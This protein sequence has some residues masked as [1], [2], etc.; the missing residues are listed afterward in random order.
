MA[1]AAS[2]IMQDS[3]FS[4]HFFVLV[5]KQRFRYAN[6]SG[7]EM[8]LIGQFFTVGS[9]DGRRTST[10]CK[11]CEVSL[12]VAPSV[13]DESLRNSNEKLAPGAEVINN[14]E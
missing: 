2:H 8:F 12:P 5:E 14:N 4:C 10:A 9:A 6:F 3:K 11:T 1:S 13:K 7:G